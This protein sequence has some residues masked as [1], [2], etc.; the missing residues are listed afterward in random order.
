MN[1]F[2]KDFNMADY[3]HQLNEE[4]KEELNKPQTDEEI[5][6]ELMED[7]IMNCLLET[8]ANVIALQAI[9]VDKG[10]TT[11]EEYAN[12]YNASKSLVI[13]SAIDAVRKEYK[14]N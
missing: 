7:P 3:L 1:M 14:N 11:M 13:K 2:D 8:S 12:A 4:L 5:E 6:K 10:I 9:L